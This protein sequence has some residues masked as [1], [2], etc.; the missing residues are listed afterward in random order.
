MANRLA[1]LSFR[2][3]FCAWRCLSVAFSDIHQCFAG[4]CSPLIKLEVFILALSC[5]VLGF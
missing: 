1:I 2:D 3:E 4:L 5:L